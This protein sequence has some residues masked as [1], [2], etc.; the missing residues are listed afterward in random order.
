MRKTD[1]EKYLVDDLLRLPGS[2]A[3]GYGI[4]HKPVAKQRCAALF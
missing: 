3:G 4:T 2:I 1:G